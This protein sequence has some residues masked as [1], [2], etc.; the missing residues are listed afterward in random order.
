MVWTQQPSPTR[1]DLHEL[2]PQDNVNS[3]Q[4]HIFTIYIL[5]YIQSHCSDVKNALNSLEN[6]YV[7]AHCSE[8]RVI[9]QSSKQHSQPIEWIEHGNRED[10]VIRL[11]KALQNGAANLA[12][13]IRQLVPRVKFHRHRDCHS[14]TEF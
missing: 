3:D 13:F 11:T 4:E 9:T 2:H 7:E 1:L 8:N 10:Q 6:G 5:H 14:G 12:V